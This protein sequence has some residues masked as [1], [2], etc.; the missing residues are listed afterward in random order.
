MKK[1]K[2]YLTG[3]TAASILFG[4]SASNAE[5]FK[6]EG[7]K[8]AKTETT[9][10]T[11]EGKCGEGKCGAE[12]MNPKDKDANCGEKMKEKDG[13]CGN[14]KEMKEK[15]GKCGEGTCGS[16]DTKTPTTPPAEVKTN[17]ADDA[18]SSGY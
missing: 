5:L 16:A 15:D 1:E 6:M 2:I 7:V 14:K 17:N 10:K 12:M 3:L 11:P 13:K 9:T 18:G 8:I 4:A